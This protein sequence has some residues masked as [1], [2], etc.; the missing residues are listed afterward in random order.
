DRLRKPHARSGAGAACNG[1]LRFYRFDSIP[2]LN[3][4][5]RHRQGLMGDFQTIGRNQKG[6]LLKDRETGQLA[7]R[8]YRPGA[9]DDR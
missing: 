6:S 5:G 4:L 1:A 7:C 8:H 9:A 2:A 3:R